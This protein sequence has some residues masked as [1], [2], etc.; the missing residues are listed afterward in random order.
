MPRTKV[1]PVK[2]NKKTHVTETRRPQSFGQ[3]VMEGIAV[4][5]GMS[6]ARNAVD[7]VIGMFSSKPVKIDGNECFMYQECLE[8]VVN[9][10][11]CDKI[12]V[13][14]ASKD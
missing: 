3:S 14:C 4:G 10:D 8:V 2:Y 12:F 5:T 1:E 7:G 9:K 11:K 13:K 6:I